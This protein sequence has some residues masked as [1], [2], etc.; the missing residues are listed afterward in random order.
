M[1]IPVFNQINSN[2]YAL[3]T[4]SSAGLPGYWA[5]YFAG[6][7]S[8]L[9]PGASTTAVW[10]DTGGFY[11]FLDRQ[12]LDWAAFTSQLTALLPRLGPQGTLRLL[13]IRHADLSFSQWQMTPGFAVSSGS[14]AGITWTLVRSFSFGVD[15]Y[16][17]SIAGQGALAYIADNAGGGISFTGS[18]SLIGPE[19]GYGFTGATILFN[20]TC[21]GAFQATMSAPVPASAALNDCWTSLRIGLQYAGAPAP[22]DPDP[23]PNAPFINPISTRIL[24]MPLFQRQESALNLGLLFDPLY[25]FMPGRTALNLFPPTLVA[26]ATDQGFKTFLRTTKGYT[27]ALTPLAASGV[28][29]AARFV[30]GYSPVQEDDP[31]AGLRCHFSPDGAFQLTVQP[32][33]ITDELTL[34]DQLLLGLSGLEYASIDGGPYQVYFQA[35]QPAFIPAV[36]RDQRN[37]PDVSKALT[38][39]ATTSHLNIL[40]LQPNVTAPIYYVQPREAP[41]FSGKGANPDGRLDFNQ[42]PAFTLQAQTAVLPPV[43]PVGIYAGLGSADAMLAREF[44]NASLA[45]YRN[46]AIGDA[47][48]TPPQLL[49]DGSYPDPQRRVRADTDP[50]GVTPQ[51]LVAELT[52]D[53]SDFDGLIIGNMPDTQY[54]TVDFTAVTGRF[55]QSLQSNQLFFVASNVTELMSGTSVRYELTD[56]DKPFLLAMGVPQATIDAVYLAVSGATQPFDTEGDFKNCISAA[57]G[58]YLP[59][60]LQIGGILKVEM[61]GWTFQLSPRSW[62]TDPS[63]PTLMIAKFCQRSL[64]ELAK[65]TGSWSWPQAAIPVGGSLGETQTILVELLLNAGADDATPGL[66]VFYET[67]VKNENWNG[68]LFLN[69]PVDIAQMPED[70]KFLTAGIDLTKFYAHHIGF[71]QTPFTVQGGIPALQQT[72]AFGLIDYQDPLDLF[73]DQSIPFGFKTTQLHVRF[74]NAGLVEFSAE[75]ELMLNDLLAAYLSKKDL[76]RGNNLILVGAY[77]RVGGVPC[78]MFT[79]TGENVYYANNAVLTNVEVLSVQLT[80]AGTGK[81]AAI[82]TTF[83]LTGDLRFFIIETFDLFSYGPAADGTDGHLRFSGLAITMRFSQA[84]PTVQTF[85][86]STENIA[87]DLRNSGL[88]STSL[89]NNFPLLLSGLLNSPDLSSAGENSS[90]QSPEDLGYTSISAP[91]EQTPMVCPWYGLVFNL[92]LG[93]FGTLTGSASFRIS[94]LAAW[95]RGSAQTDIPVYL[96]LQLPGIPAIAGSFPLQGVLKLGFRSFR[97][98]TYNTPEGQIGYLLRLTQFALSVLMW[99]FPPGNSQIVLFGEPGNPTGSL[100]WY[101]AYDNGEDNNKVSRRLQSGRRTPPL[102]SNY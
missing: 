9:G 25:L 22:P 51:G 86:V 93:T 77:Q 60:F 21:L 72:A 67:V 41:I 47:Y 61:D 40:A 28:L 52:A 55:K 56:A 50:L 31:S 78:Y 49:P 13:W 69:T 44:E 23:P 37:P 33:R 81:D 7:Q 18:G 73:A 17:L 68:F 59:S 48:S 35:G 58:S 57:A 43:F 32:K 34:P 74:A 85:T 94:V 71:S 30:L 99:S 26:S 12:P 100:G 20:G 64:L 11:L 76:M 4:L 5:G 1:S 42:M 6:P 92:D 63:S 24:F 29:P 89:V 70:L 88:R 75:T 16:L 90:G 36:L 87:F 66:K 54:P 10:Q 46:Y 8:S 15:A 97:F 14:G 102:G 2:L 96:G 79:L 82:L 45:P 101:A 84:A 83:T 27:I 62:R 19:G 39:L 53:Y 98:E 3:S 91:L 80:T 95:S 65:D 38:D